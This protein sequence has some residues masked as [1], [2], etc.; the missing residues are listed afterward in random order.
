M[1]SEI[2]VP[3]L[4]EQHNLIMENLFVNIKKLFDK[5]DLAKMTFHNEAAEF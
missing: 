5:M 1:K 3:T 2:L 4:E